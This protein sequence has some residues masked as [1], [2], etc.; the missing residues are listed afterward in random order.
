[1]VL[2]GLLLVAAAAVLGS[3]IVLSN[4]QTTTGEAFN[5]TAA[6][7]TAGEFFLGGAGTA[8]LLVLG[9]LMMFG[10]ISRRRRRRAHSRHAMTEQRREVETT[11]NELSDVGEEN[12][13]LR[14]ELQQERLHR[15][16]LGGVQ[17]PPELAD[18]SFE[19]YPGMANQAMPEPERA[20]TRTRD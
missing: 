3:E 12:E 6:G 17:V 19:P 10:G 14:R 8:L 2:I 11:E 20:E 9:L 18:T 13:R 15:E 16:T 4:T 5:Q 7:V 1:M